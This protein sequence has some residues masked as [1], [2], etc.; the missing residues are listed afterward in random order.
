[1][2]LSCMGVQME[3]TIVSSIVLKPARPGGSNRDPADSWLQL[4]RV[5]EKIG[6]GKTSVT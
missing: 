2:Q 6:K 3:K 4:G 5:E 1:M